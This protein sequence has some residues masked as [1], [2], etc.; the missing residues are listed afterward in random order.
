MTDSDNLIFCVRADMALFNAGISSATEAIN[1]SAAAFRAAIDA[2]P[3]WP[4]YFRKWERAR[5]GVI[6]RQ[7][8]ARIR[9]RGW[10]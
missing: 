3:D 8:R 4:A 1:E 9:R 7:R 6:R 2:M 10:A 5:K